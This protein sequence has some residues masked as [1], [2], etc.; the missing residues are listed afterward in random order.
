MG[1]L[2]KLQVSCSERVIR[3]KNMQGG[4]WRFGGFYLLRFVFKCFAYLIT[5]SENIMMH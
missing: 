1:C 4:L 2:L 5:M 3:M